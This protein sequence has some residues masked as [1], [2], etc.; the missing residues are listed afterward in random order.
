MGKKRE[1][2]PFLIS[3]VA[4]FI[5]ATLLGSAVAQDSN[6][7]IK[8]I[9]IDPGHG[10]K[11]P[12]NLGTGRYKTTESDIVLEVSLKLRDY[13]NEY[14]PDVEVVMTRTED[15]FPALHERSALANAEDAQLYISIHC[16]AFHKKEA[17][18]SSTYVMGMHKSEANMEVA[19]RENQ[20]IYM[21]D[22]Y[23]EH[24]EGF[25]PN[26]PSSIIALSMMQQ[27]FLDQSIYFAD[28]VQDQFRDRVHRKDRG[29]KQAGFWVISRTVMPSVLVELG[30]LTNPG[31][32]DF[33]NTEEGQ[34]YMASAIYRAFKDY[35]QTME[36]VDPEGDDI[37]E[38]RVVEGNSNDQNNDGAP[39]Q[40]PNE[41]AVLPSNELVYKVQ[42]AS[43]STPVDLRPENFRGVEGVEEMKM[44][45]GVFKY[46]VG[47]FDNFDDA[48]ELQR[49]IREQSYKDAFIIA[50]YQGKRISLQEAFSLGK[51]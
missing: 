39:D 28:L 26:S 15:V 2:F 27:Q 20:V 13:I 42:L 24:Y 14:L 50:I 17:S 10:G 3:V 37:E 12:G 9:V 49:Q 6:Y 35:K 22:N 23:E 47:N 33:L 7:R 51:N 8:K 1:S 48:V 38:Q 21:E 30:F 25:D 34:A 46:L 16:D 18:G 19:K 11:D 31:E 4:F 44:E 29:V 36:G 41:V 45:D 43:S 5:G 32:E 40:E